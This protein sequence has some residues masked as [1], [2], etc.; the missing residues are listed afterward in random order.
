MLSCSMQEFYCSISGIYD[1]H[2]S[3]P[4]T[5]STRKISKPLPDWGPSYIH[6]ATM[7]NTRLLKRTHCSHV[8][9]RDRWTQENIQGHAQIFL[10]EN[11]T[12]HYHLG[13]PGPQ[14]PNIEEC[15]GWHWDPHRYTL[16]SK[17]T[18]GADNFM[19]YPSTCPVN[20]HP[21]I[22]SSHTDLITIGNTTMLV[23]NHPQSRGKSQE[24]RKKM[25]SS[26][27]EDTILIITV[28]EAGSGD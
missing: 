1:K 21:M 14:S 3:V 15:L 19:N 24:G 17:L 2:L 28:A 20:N 7:G 11:A 5:I 10:V 23:V 9:H 18:E 25:T 6:F 8:S 12:P 26:R 27:R 16:G 4:S 22:H 13:I